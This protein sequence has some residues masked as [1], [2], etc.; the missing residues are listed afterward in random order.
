MTTSAVLNLLLLGTS[1]TA[2]AEL[3]IE[4]VAEPL[5]A[6]ATKGRIE[7]AVHELGFAVT[8]ETRYRVLPDGRVELYCAQSAPPTLQG[9]VRER[10]LA[11]PY[12]EER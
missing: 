7:S 12:A 5:N 4:V 6:R 3:R 10:R 1:L 11:K 8:T 2:A 9:A